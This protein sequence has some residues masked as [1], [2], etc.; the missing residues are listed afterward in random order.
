MSYHERKPGVWE[1]RY[2][3]GGRNRSKAVRGSKTD[4]RRVDA[5]MKAKVSAGTIS[6]VTAGRQTFN[7]LAEDVWEARADDWE[8]NTRNLYSWLLDTHIIPYIG[9]VRISDISVD[10]L[11]D[12]KATLRRKGV[13][14]ESV[15]KA[16]KLVRTILRQGVKRGRI[17]SNPAEHVDLPAPPESKQ[18]VPLSPSEVWAI[19]DALSRQGRPSDA[20]LVLLMGFA[21]L[22]PEEALGLT[23]GHV[24]DR[25][26]LIEQVVSAGELRHSTKNRKT[27][28]VTLLA[29]LPAELAALDLASGRPSR[30]SLIFIAENDGHWSDTKY[31]NWRARVFGKALEES[32]VAKMRRE[33]GLP[34]PTPYY[35]RHSYAS[36]LI[37]EGKREAYTA[38]QLG[39][40]PT[41]TTNT[42]AHVIDELEG[43]DFT[44]A[45]E[46]ILASRPKKVNA[47]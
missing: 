12:W 37:W 17:A 45:E 46:A 5:E 6:Q 25:T 23:W 47:A 19:S 15:R 24:R 1:V 26:L 30:S 29:P 22:R 41:Q 43:G 38:R 39:H 3:E 14:R 11:E 20:V 35:L 9:H 10:T 28:T 16:I 7:E 18:I 31:N 33:S 8:K 42:Y 2:R 40:L 27:R 36:L 34:K 32:G 44:T 13:G 4:A 21:G